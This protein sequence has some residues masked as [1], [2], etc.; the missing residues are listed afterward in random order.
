MTGYP[1]RGEIYLVTFDPAL[2]HEIRKTRPAV[3]S[4]NDI[5]NQWS[6]I[7]IMAAVS[8]Q[9]GDPPHP[10]KV[11]LP[12][13]AGLP[14]PSAAILN[15]IRPVDRKRLIKKLGSL[16]AATMR[17]VD[18]ALTISLG[19]MKLQRVNAFPRAPID[20]VFA[21]GSR[22]VCLGWQNTAAGQRDDGIPVYSTTVARTVD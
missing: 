10:R 13:K 9:F 18:E 19:L 17:K 4:Q 21:L 22:G 20:R 5:S 1:R 11:P 3:V 8:S 7:A 14:K 16:D 2:G 12:A 15:Q 6:P